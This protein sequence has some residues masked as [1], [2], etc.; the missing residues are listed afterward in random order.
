MKVGIPRALLY[1]HYGE[2]WFSFLE[3]LGIEVVVSDPTTTDILNKG[4]GKADNETCLPVKVFTGH[5]MQILDDVDVLLIPRLISQEPGTCSCPK[6]L[7]LPDIARSVDPYV[8]Q[9]LSPIINLNDRRYTWLREWYKVA[10]ALGASRIASA[11]AVRKLVAGISQER[12]AHLP[13]DDFDAQL[14]IG[15]AGH[16]YNVKD[17][18]VSLGLIDRLRQMDAKA[19]TVESTS[20]REAHTQAGT[21]SRGIF[22]GY[23]RRLAGSVLQWSRSST[24]S[25]IIYLTSFACGPGS[26]V[27]A[28]LEDQLGRE[29]SVP[30]MTITLDEHSGEAGLITRLEAFTDMLKRS[31]YSQAPVF[32]LG[33]R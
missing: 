26:F 11:A 8:P 10:R 17:S 16:Y 7:G 33:E 9:V 15:V 24:V 30:L 31:N 6:F 14:T 4:V 28:L 19:V 3:T 25:G 22:W 29:T 27:G 13:P 1:H 5:L 18:F 12:K 2:F 23:E 21:L 20:H 32:E